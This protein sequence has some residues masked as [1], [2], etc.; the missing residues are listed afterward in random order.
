MKY[1]ILFFFIL[2]SSFS[3]SQCTTVSMY[4]KLN[5]SKSDNDKLKIYLEM[6]RDGFENVCSYI[7]ECSFRL[8][9][10]EIGR[11]YLIRAIKKGMTI[12]GE[13]TNYIPK[14]ILEKVK[15]KY[16]KWRSIF[17]KTYDEEMYNKILYLVNA[18]QYLAREDFYGG[19]EQQYPIR[20]KV[21]Q[22]NLTQLRYYLI[23]KNNGRLPHCNQI[24]NLTTA[25]SLM[26]IHRTCNDSIDDVNY[27]FFEPLLRE[28]ICTGKTY[29]PYAYLQLVDN[30]QSI[31]EKGLPQVY[32]HFRDYKTKKIHLLKYPE[33]VDSLRVSIGLMPLKEYA[34]EKGFL[35][36]DNY[37]E[38]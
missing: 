34:K 14:K 2:K 20:I 1:I 31:M 28:E 25:I 38:K 30:M 24:G 19:R 17:Y 35:L 13:Y 9:K 23:S 33:K 36:P 37:I 18:D 27:R 32:G 16:P 11:R 7:V 8:K 29:S 15:K 22:N 3:I 21:F 26:F 10:N 5:K 6:Y 12:E 4:N